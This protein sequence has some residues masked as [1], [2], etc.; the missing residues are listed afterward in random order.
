MKNENVVTLDKTLFAETVDCLAT[1]IHPN[2]SFAQVNEL[3]RRLQENASKQ[4][5]QPDKK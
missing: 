4:S 5:V 1:A 2:R 3:L